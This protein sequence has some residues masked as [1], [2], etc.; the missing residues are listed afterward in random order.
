MRDFVKTRKYGN[1]KAGLSKGDEEIFRRKVYLHIFFNAARKVDEGQC[2]EHDLIS[3]GKLLEDGT[4]L[5]ELSGPAQK[6]AEKYL[7]I[8]ARK[9]TTR[10]SYNEIACAQAKRYHGYFA[11]VSN[12]EKDTFLALSKYRK[13]EHIEDY[14]RSAN[15]NTDSAHV[16][17]W[18]AD[19]LR[20]RM[21]IQFIALCY[22]EFLSEKVRLMKLS[23]G[24]NLTSCAK[25]QNSRSN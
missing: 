6:K 17:V 10:I 18:D 5:S 12:S 24:K 23:L 1:R 13:R 7:V 11:L 14:F 25:D 2:F 16:R 9:K 15:Q 21:F 4:S 20:G 8:K 19:T 3:I 22:Y